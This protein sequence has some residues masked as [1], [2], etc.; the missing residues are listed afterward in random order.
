MVQIVTPGMWCQMPDCQKGS[1][2]AGNVVPTWLINGYIKS[3]EYICRQCAACLYIPQ[4]GLVSVRHKNIYSLMPGCHQFLQYK[5]TQNSLLVHQYN[6][7][8]QCVY[9]STGRRKVCLHCLLPLCGD[10]SWDTNIELGNIM[11]TWIKFLVPSCTQTEKIIYNYV[12][13]WY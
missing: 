5:C 10:F 1:A 11:S 8:K 6:C 3:S 7:S 4:C 9:T 13:G 2:D 12:S